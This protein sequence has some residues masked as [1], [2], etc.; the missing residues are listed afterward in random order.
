MNTLLVE[1]ID[2]GLML[3]LNRLGGVGAAFLENGPQNSEIADP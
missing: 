2:G 1:R 3:T